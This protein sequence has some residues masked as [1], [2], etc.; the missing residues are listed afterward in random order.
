MMSVKLIPAQFIAIEASVS[1]RTTGPKVSG[2]TE[3]RGTYYL[4]DE[5]L[6]FRED[7]RVLARTLQHS[8][9]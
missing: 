9:A 6:H 3:E 4:V 5:V 1:K 8:P 2:I 7:L